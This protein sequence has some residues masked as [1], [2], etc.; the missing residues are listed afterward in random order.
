ME[1][2]GHRD[3]QGVMKEV[4][5]VREAYLEH[6]GKRSSNADFVA[7]CKLGNTHLREVVSHPNFLKD[8]KLLQGTMSS[9]SSF[10]A[11]SARPSVSLLVVSWDKGG[12]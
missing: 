8:P 11:C 1:K 5:A 9:L 3:L 6:M 10:L 12:D 7:N 4:L 2:L